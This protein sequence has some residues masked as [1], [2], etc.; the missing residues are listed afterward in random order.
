MHVN[1][2]VHNRQIEIKIINS[3]SVPTKSINKNKTRFL[4]EKSI[5]CEYG[6]GGLQII[7]AGN[8]GRFQGIENIIHAFK[9]LNEYD[10]IRLTILG[11]GF[12]KNKLQNSF[13]LNR[14]LIIRA[15]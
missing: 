8:I 13:I 6:N 11:E 3:L 10:D 7:F 5:N 14:Q 15:L 12:E 9:Y 1:M 2:K 4:Y